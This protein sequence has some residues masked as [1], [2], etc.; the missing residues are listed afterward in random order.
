L[1]KL[2]IRKIEGQ[3]EVLNIQYLHRT[4]WGLDDLEVIPGHI[5]LA[6]Q[7]ANGLG[8]CAYSGKEP[9]GFIF[10]FLGMS[11]QDHI[12]LHMHNIAVLEAYRNQGIAFQMMLEARDQ[13]LARGIERIDWTYEP[14]E[15]RNANLYMNKLRCIGKRYVHNYYGF[16]PDQLNEDMPSDRLIAEWWL[17]DK[18]VIDCLSATS[19]GQSRPDAPNQGVLNRTIIGPLG[20]RK[21]EKV[22]WD[23]NCIA[24]GTP[25]FVYI[26][27]PTNFQEIRQQNFDLAL[28]WRLSL[29]DLLDNCF[30]HGLFING[31]LYTGDRA[32]YRLGKLD[33]VDKD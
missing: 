17:K 14:L 19:K 12:Y 29:R 30:A 23:V 25:S 33:E 13:M 3:Q 20:L 21:P 31:F 6:I 16:M 2:I 4:I 24:R 5:L 7:K 27:I 11:P 32:F 9:V 26:E 8:L 15:S 10:G 28:E 1:E 18:R 22:S